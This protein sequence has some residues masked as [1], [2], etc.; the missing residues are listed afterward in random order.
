MLIDCKCKSVFNFF[1]R[2]THGQFIYRYFLLFHALSCRLFYYTVPSHA[3]THH[4]VD[5]FLLQNRNFHL[6]KKKNNKIIL[7]IGLLFKVL[8][9]KRDILT[10]TLISRFHD[11]CIFLINDIKAFTKFHRSHRICIQ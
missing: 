2:N 4:I 10:K 3:C 9:N 11:M 8:Y 1:L 6:N 7:D 5:I